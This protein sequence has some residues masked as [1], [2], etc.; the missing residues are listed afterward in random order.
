M[1][2][3][4][5]TL[6]PEI[7]SSPLKCSILGK[8][9]ERGV[10]QVEV[11]NIRDYAE[12]RHRVTDDYPY[13]GGKGMIMKPEPIV[14]AI[15]ALLE[16]DPKTWVVL[17]T[18]QGVPFDQRAAKRLASFGHIA[19]VCGR[20]EGVDERVRS[21]VNEE[22]SI[23]DYV[24]SGGEFAALVVIDAVSRLVPGVLGDAEA[25]EE[26]SF[27]EGLLEYPQYTRPPEFEGKRVPEVLLSGNHGRIRGW[28]R[29]QALLRTWQRRPDLL[30]EAALGEDERRYLE[31]LR[32]GRDGL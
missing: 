3:H 22:L 24:L 27:S 32:E 7:F 10:V 21:F 14:R 26:D 9:R 13:G 12:G 1:T 6:F 23:G 5:L 29:R 19:L 2:F 28:R 15:R 25:P 20:Y 4:V 31:G 16:A 30:Q 11:I 18:P 17:M 8:A